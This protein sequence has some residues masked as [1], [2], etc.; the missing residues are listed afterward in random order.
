MRYLRF[1]VYLLG[2]LALTSMS[3]SA[4]AAGLLRIEQTIFGMDCAPCAHSTERALKGLPGVEQVT[5]SLNRGEAVLTLSPDSPTTL[6]QVR[7]VI[8]NNGFTPKAAAVSAAGELET[9]GEV[10]TLS[11]GAAG[12]FTLEPA[13]DGAALRALQ[14]LPEGS[15][16]HVMGRVEEEAGGSPPLSV[17]E[18][19]AIEAEEGA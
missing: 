12:S 19:H 4:N 11:V 1:S 10:L 2:A 9:S 16:V 6:S 7:E 17:T 8:R 5:V 14:Q 3:V 18:A 15:A 13:E